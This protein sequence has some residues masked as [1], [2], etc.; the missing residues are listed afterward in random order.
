MLQFEE[1]KN[2]AIA[3]KGGMGHMEAAKGRRLSL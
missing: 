2:V 3:K 1:G